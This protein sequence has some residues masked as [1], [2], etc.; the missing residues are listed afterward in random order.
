MT[1]QVCIFDIDDTL[2]RLGELLPE[3]EA[4]LKDLKAR[5][6]RLVI[7]T[8]RGTPMLPPDIKRLEAL[9]D[10]IITANGQHVKAGQDMVR[11]EE[12]TPEALQF[13]LELGDRYGLYPQQAGDTH[14]ALR[15]A[16]PRYDHIA[17]TYPC[18]II[19]PNFSAPVYQFSYLFPE[20]FSQESAL[21]ADLNA[22]G[23]ELIPWRRLGA[24]VIPRG[25]SKLTGIEALARHWNINMDTI[26]AFGDGLNDREMLQGVGIGVA[27]G[28][29]KD[30]VKE[31]ADYVSAAFDHHGLHQACRHFGLWEA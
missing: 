19:E 8:G 5:A 31:A 26:I 23:F 28:N 3:N 16:L 13:L 1:I 24:D 14:I 10:A 20:D 22:A 21:R 4:L 30:A 6:Y 7:A 11:A 2:C 18:F 12:V 25:C 29:A 17:S 9:F 15:E 27:L